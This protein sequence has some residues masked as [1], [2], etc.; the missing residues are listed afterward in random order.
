MHWIL[1][2]RKTLTVNTDPRAVRS[3]QALLEALLALLE[4][5]PWEQITI[6]DICAQARVGYTTFFRHH[7]TKESLLND[8]AADQIRILIN[9]SLPVMDAH[10]VRAGSAALFAFVKAHRPM[11]TTLLTGGAAATIREE[12][13]RQ[14]REVGKARMPPGG[15]LRAEAGAL[16]IVSGTIELLTWWLRQDNPLSIDQI[17]ELH[18]ELVVSPIIAAN[19]RA[20]SGAKPAARKAASTRARKSRTTGG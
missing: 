10:D 3:R 15:P 17:A 7:P 19:F 11:W 2:R 5:R 4:T 12:F 8:V 6:R 20:P 13:L 9:L 14:A 18:D 16:L 1:P